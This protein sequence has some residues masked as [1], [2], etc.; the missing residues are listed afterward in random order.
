MGSL[1]NSQQHW[2]KPGKNL[3][4]RIWAGPADG[5]GR[6]QRP[7]GRC[8]HVFSVDGSSI[9]CGPLSPHQKKKRGP[10]RWLVGGWQSRPPINGRVRPTE[11]PPESS[12]L[13]KMHFLG[14]DFSQ[15]ILWFTMRVSEPG[16]FSLEHKTLWLHLFYTSFFNYMSLRIPKLPLGSYLRPLK[17]KTTATMREPELEVETR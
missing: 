12:W 9:F 6:V 13:K 1:K 3:L 11:N 16:F 4:K 10:G 7:S 17:K 15:F 14:I 2:I 8:A 5:F